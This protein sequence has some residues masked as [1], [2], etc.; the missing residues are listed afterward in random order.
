MILCANADWDSHI[1]VNLENMRKANIPEENI[2]Y[3]LM[4]LDGMFG[5]I[6]NDQR[7][8]ESQKNVYLTAASAIF[9]AKSLGV[10][11]CVIQGFNV[12]AISQA[13]ELTPELV[14]TLI[15]TWGYAVDSVTPKDRL[16]E[17]EIFF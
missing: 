5:Q 4:A 16:P 15:I 17:E 9:G 7:I 10:D 14:P 6:N 8:V 1:K 11:S 3:Y 2:N 13:L 12:E